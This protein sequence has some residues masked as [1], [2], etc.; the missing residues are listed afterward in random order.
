VAAGDVDRGFA[1]E[2][3]ELA[4]AQLIGCPGPLSAQTGAP[5]AEA[6]EQT[7]GGQAFDEG[8][9]CGVVEGMRWK[10]PFD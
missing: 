1:D 2:Q 4:A 5:Q 8:A 9:S 7:A 3:L 10:S 6:A